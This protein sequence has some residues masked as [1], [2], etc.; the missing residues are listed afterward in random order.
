MKKEKKDTLKIFGK[1]QT[2]EIKIGSIIHLQG[3]LNY[4]YV[5][6]ETEKFLSAKTLKTYEEV[7][8]SKVFI[9]THKSH[10]INQSK[11]KD[12]SDMDTLRQVELNDGTRIDISRRKFKEVKKRITEHQKKFSEKIL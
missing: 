8:D 11:I 6:T 12:L 3:E 4:T 1:K 5:Y 2:R 10:L 9:R 7:L